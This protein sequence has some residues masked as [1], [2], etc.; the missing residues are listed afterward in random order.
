MSVRVFKQIFYGFIFL[1]IIIG[2]LTFF[3]FIFKPK[4][5]CFDGKKNQGE[6][7]IDCGGP[8]SQVCFPPDFRNVEVLWTKLLDAKSQ[9]IL[10]AKIQNPN[11]DL[12]SDSFDYKFNILSNGVVLKTIQG[13]SFI[14]AE[15]IKYI[16]EFINKDS[17]I[18]IDDLEIEFI[19]KNVN[20]VKSKNFS[21]PK[22]DLIS[23]DIQLKDD[24]NY[25][26]GRI[27]NN[28]FVS[29]NNVQILVNV[30]DNK[31]LILNSK[32]LIDNISPA[33][34]KNFQIIFPKN[35]DISKYTLEIIIEA[36]RQ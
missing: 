10:V 2:L 25:L 15:E 4:P 1:I 16:E 32:T 5:S 6:E 13:K 28:D 33:E 24:F 12:A 26:I 18:N 23:K 11:S 21:K 30:Y 31:L 7:G 35:I 17:I 34:T 29:L 27:K 3:Y 20:W 22:I 14:Y 19:I 8:C 9:L 36:K